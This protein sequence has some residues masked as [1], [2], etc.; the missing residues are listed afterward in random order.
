MLSTMLF[1]LLLVLAVLAVWY[2]ELDVDLA[3]YRDQFWNPYT[4]AHIAGA[5]ALV[6]AGV[7][8]GVAL[9]PAALIVFA[10]GILY[11]LAQ[12]LPSP[13][14]RIARRR[15]PWLRIWQTSWRDILANA[16]G[17]VA[18]VLWTQAWL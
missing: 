3:D 4:W 7:L 1:A 14:S 8:A 13:R 2:F 11:E 12:K 5:G 9:R 17:I 18:A 10:I 15:P 16:A 6:F